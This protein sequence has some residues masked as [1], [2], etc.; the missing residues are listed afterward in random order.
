MRA[1]S[2]T[3]RS[4]EPDHNEEIAES[5]ANE[6]RAPTDQY[7]GRPVTVADAAPNAIRTITTA[8]AARAAQ[9]RSATPKP[10]PARARPVSRAIGARPAR[11]FA[12][13]GVHDPLFGTDPTPGAALGAASACGCDRMFVLACGRDG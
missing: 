2:M 8:Q 10:P 3:V 6:T 13:L 5:N 1:V 11:A 12:N 7:N 9:W 4:T